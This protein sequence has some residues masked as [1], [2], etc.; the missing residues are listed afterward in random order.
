MTSY[1]ILFRFVVTVEDQGNPASL[2]TT[3]T[4]DVIAQDMTT[5]T[6]TTTTIATTPYNFWKDPGSCVVFGLTMFGIAG[7]F[8]MDPEVINF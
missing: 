3:V 6:T 1:V 5:T 4:V 8:G 2:S 7:I